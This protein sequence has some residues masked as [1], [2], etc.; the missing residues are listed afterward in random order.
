MHEKHH[1]LRWAGGD[2][3]DF[4]FWWDRLARVTGQYTRVLMLGDSM[5]AT[6]ALLFSP[7]ATNVHAFAPQVCPCLVCTP[8]PRVLLLPVFL[9]HTASKIE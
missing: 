7:L 5:G 6:A 8:A 3:E 9:V 4:Q 2:D 1:V